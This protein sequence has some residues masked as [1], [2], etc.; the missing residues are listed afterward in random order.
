MTLWCISPGFYTIYKVGVNVSIVQVDKTSPIEIGSCFKHNTNLFG[1]FV[2]YIC[3]MLSPLHFTVKNNTQILVCFYVRQERIVPNY[4][5][6]N[7]W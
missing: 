2:L 1:Y 3:N 7:I 4:G 5:T 6:L